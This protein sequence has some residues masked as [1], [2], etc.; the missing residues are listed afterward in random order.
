MY[1][2]DYDNTLLS[3]NDFADAKETLRITKLSNND[4]QGVTVPKPT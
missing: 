3:D 2:L 4:E 1:I